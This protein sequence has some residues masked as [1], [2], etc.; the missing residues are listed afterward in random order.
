MGNDA[1]HAR[2]LEQI[3]SR[4]IAGISRNAALGEM[5]RE[6]APGGIGVRDRWL[7]CVGIA[8]FV[9]G[10]GAGPGVGAARYDIDDVTGGESTP[11]ERAEDRAG[12]ASEVGFRVRDDG[13]ITVGV[14]ESGETAEAHR[15]R[16]RRE[17]E[18]RELER[19]V[20]SLS[21]ERESPALAPRSLR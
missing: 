4:R 7:R 1:E 5:V 20:G 2:S 8:L 21:G 18:E 13:R 19:D 14:A 3:G 17:E 11:E 10:C 16:I 12:D 6:L 15:A 9:A